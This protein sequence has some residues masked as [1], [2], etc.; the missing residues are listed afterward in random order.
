MLLESGGRQYDSVPLSRIVLLR[1]DKPYF[2]GQN[3]LLWLEG[4]SGLPMPAQIYA[5]KTVL[6]PSQDFGKVSLFEVG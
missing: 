6:K 5:N 4:A 2:S 1:Q 3:L